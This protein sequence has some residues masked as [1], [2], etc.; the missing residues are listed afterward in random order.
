MPLA[1]VMGIP[2]S[3][4]W[5]VGKLIGKKIVINEFLAFAELGGYIKAGEIQVQFL[6]DKNFPLTLVTLCP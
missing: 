3:Q 4:C 6:Y 1:F 2:W 5:M